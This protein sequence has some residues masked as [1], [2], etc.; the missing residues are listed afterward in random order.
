[1]TKRKPYGRMKPTRKNITRGAYMRG[2]IAYA[3]AMKDDRE[4]AA[5]T[6]IA[7]SSNAAALLIMNYGFTK[8]EAAEFVEKSRAK[9]Q[10]NSNASVKD[11]DGSGKETK[12]MLD[13][14]TVVTAVSISQVLEDDYDFERDD[15]RV[16]A[17]AAAAEATTAF[18][19]AH[20]LKVV[21]KRGLLH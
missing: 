11:K 10:Y 12:S 7:I 16:V 19:E 5:G 2:K 14:A 6:F 18:N 17:G 20:R 15:A 8:K 4:I 13:R 3:E 21:D 9:S 1:M